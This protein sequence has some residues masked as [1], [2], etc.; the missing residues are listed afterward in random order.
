MQHQQLQQRNDL[1]LLLN[2][3]KTGAVIGAS[4][5]AAVNLHRMRRDE[6]EWQ[7]A[8]RNTVA[9]GFTVGVATSAA[10][11]VGR[12]VG[13]NPWLSLAATLAT[14]TAVMYVLQDQRKE[15][16]DE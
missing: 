13:S 14:G 7:Q 8:L 12:M 3:A 16:A 5:A 2:A 6:I 10:A 1:D 4:G 15:A 11:A 9:A